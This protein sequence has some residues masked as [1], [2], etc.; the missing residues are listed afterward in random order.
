MIGNLKKKCPKE[1]YSYEY[2]LK[3]EE[4]IENM[5]GFQEAIWERKKRMRE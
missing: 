3:F 2:V 1:D 5:K 4:Y